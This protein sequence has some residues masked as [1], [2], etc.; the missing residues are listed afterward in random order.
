MSHV[1]NSHSLN[2]IT[3]HTTIKTITLRKDARHA[4]CQTS[5]LT[6]HINILARTTMSSLQATC[7]GR[8]KCIRLI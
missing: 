5:A 7:H 2:T 1:L 4:A 6:H 3:I 8:V